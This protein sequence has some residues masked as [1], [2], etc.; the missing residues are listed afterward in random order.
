MRK[1]TTYLNL[2]KQYSFKK[3]HKPEVD[4]ALKLS[5]I[6]GLSLS[7]VFTIY[8]VYFVTENVVDPAQLTESTLYIAYAG[9]CGLFLKFF[10][11]ATKCNRNRKGGLIF[12]LF[13]FALSQGANGYQQYDKNWEYSKYIPMVAYPMI[14]AVC[15]SSYHKMLKEMFPFRVTA[16]G[17]S[18]T[19]F[20]SLIATCIFPFLDAKQDDNSI[21]HYFSWAIGGA[22]L[23]STLLF[24][25]FT[26]DT[27]GKDKTFIF[28]KIRG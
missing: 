17:I 21:L 20:F 13:M 12:G 6:M 24:A 10:L 19:L 25:I 9:G 18:N 22:S 23:I 4:K 14:G 26:F 3:I 28:K 5:L 15:M 11:M 8:S 27:A 16:F 1:S 2:K 7:T